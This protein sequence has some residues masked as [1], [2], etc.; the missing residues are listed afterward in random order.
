MLSFIVNLIKFSKNIKN[1]LTVLISLK[2]NHLSK[3]FLFDDIIHICL[4]YL[5]FDMLYFMLYNIQLLE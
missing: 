5:C 3:I 4:P 2:S 1:E